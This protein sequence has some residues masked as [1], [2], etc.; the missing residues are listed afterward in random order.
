[1]TCA[2]LGCSVVN[3]GGVPMVMSPTGFGDFVTEEVEKYARVIKA[4][5]IKPE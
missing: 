5:N 3:L 1:M 4:A 2:R